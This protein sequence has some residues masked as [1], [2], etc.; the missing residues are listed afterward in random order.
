MKII[1]KC[2]KTKRHLC[3]SGSILLP[4]AQKWG[5]AGVVACGLSLI[6]AGN[7]SAASI[8]LSTPSALVINVT[9]TEE[10]KFAKS[11]LGSF[12]V[13]SDAYA[14]YTLKIRGNSDDN[15]LVDG[16]KKLPSL[17]STSGISETA[18]NTA[19]YNNKWGYKPSKFNGNTNDKF[20]PGPKFGGDIID[21]TENANIDANNYTVE[22]GVR[23]SN[24]QAA[25]TYKGTFII[26]AVANDLRYSITYDGNGAAMDDMPENQSG[27][28]P[29]GKSFIIGDAPTLE[30][31]YFA[32]WCDKATMDETC[33]GKYIS[34]GTVIR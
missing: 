25:G 21:K 12:S 18:F 19:A 14:G 11:N 5:L 6:G 28:A 1:H 10:G 29:E 23:I 3:A 7:V 16:D 32:G 2:N 30:D 17:E 15:A 26:S 34:L 31:Y 33:S 22:L 8:T 20:L 24:A 9:P 27:T 13:T 4:L